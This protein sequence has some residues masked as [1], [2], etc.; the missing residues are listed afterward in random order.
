M[1]RLIYNS[2][3]TIFIDDRTLAHLQAVFSTKLR[4]K[5]SFNFAWRDETDAGTG[6]GRNLI[7]VYPGVALVYAFSSSRTPHLNPEWIH[8]LL[9][10]ANS[11]DGL[12]IV[13]EPSSGVIGRP[14]LVTDA[15]AHDKV[16]APTTCGT[17]FCVSGER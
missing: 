15:P 5:E 16:E 9:G 8:A 10:T 4:H 1:G 11:A 17:A 14:D 3:L 7:W 6:G 12:S 13:P 2:T